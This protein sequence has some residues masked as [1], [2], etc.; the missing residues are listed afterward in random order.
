MENCVLMTAGSRNA[1]EPAPASR[2][3]NTSARQLQLEEES[4]EVRCD[5]G[6]F[7]FIPLDVQGSQQM[8]YGESQVRFSRVLDHSYRYTL[9]NRSLTSTMIS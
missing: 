3:N 4:L 1:S 9:P 5:G 7:G 2:S 6:R 8:I